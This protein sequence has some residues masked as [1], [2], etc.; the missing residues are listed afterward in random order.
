MA[1]SPSIV[2]PEAGV[3]RRVFLLNLTALHSQSSQS[4]CASKSTTRRCATAAKAKASTSRCKTSCCWPSGSMSLGFD[5]VEGGYPLSNE[6]DAQ[7]FQRV[8]QAA[9]RP[10]P[11]SAAFGMTRR[12]GSRPERDPGMKALLDSRCAARSRSSARLGFSCHRSVA[13]HAGRKP[14]DDRRHD[15]AIFA[16]AGRE[17]IY[18]AEHFF[19]GWKAN[20]DYALQTIQAA[21]EAGAAADRA[22][23]YQ[24]RQPAGRRSPS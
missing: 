7:F 11:G 6:K 5:F 21:A 13:G 15:R 19:D 12:K 3:G 18:D 2:C 10:C 1:D 8:Q 4:V 24:R 9:A 23:R 20:P 16:P 22:L 14:G 17:V